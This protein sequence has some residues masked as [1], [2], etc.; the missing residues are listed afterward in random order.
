MFHDARQFAF[1]APLEAAWQEIRA[2]FLRVRQ[3]MTEWTERELYNHGWEVF[4]LFDF[5]NGEAIPANAS[6][7]PITTALVERHFPRHGAAGFSLLQART[8]IRPHEGYQ[9]E[10]LRCHLGLQVPGGDCALRVLEE[11]RRWEEGRMLVF[12]DRVLHEAWNHTDEERA[13]LLVD[14][15]P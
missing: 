15:I 3:S 11:S 12:D 9:G 8:H 1:T 5:P 13:V 14:F 6:R 7:C 2:E 10:F 4:R